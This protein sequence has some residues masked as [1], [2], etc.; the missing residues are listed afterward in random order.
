MKNC[1]K[2]IIG[3]WLALTLLASSGVSAQSVDSIVF[4]LS[5]AFSN[6][7]AESFS[8]VLLIDN[9]L[10]N[11]HSPGFDLTDA[12]A[13]THTTGA[14][15]FQWGVGGGNT[16]AHPSAL[17]FEP[18]SPT[19]S[20]VPEESFDLGYLYYRNGTINSG[21]GASAVDLT[22]NLVF[23]EPLGLPNQSTSYTQTLINTVN[24]DDPVASADIVSLNNVGT[25][26]NFFDAEGNQY[27]LELTFRVDQDTQ[28]NSLSTPDEF[29]VFEGGTGRAELIGRFTVAPVPEPGSALLLGLSLLACL[30]RSRR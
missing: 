17:W 12:P 6:P 23:S 29:R 22:L 5:G 30:R 10:T 28:D 21:S 15:A 27:F 26:L 13:I 4:Q 18:L 7:V 20:A 16:Y 1:K 14:A 24:T 25:P 11:G 2:K 19:I 3:S 9:N 8:S